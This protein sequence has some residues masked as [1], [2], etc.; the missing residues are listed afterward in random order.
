MSTSIHSSQHL[1]C[2]FSIIA[3]LTAW[4][5]S[6]WVFRHIFF[7]MGDI[8]HF[9]HILFEQCISSSE[10]CALLFVVNIFK[11]WD[12]QGFYLLVFCYQTE[13]VPC[14]V[15]WKETI[16]RVKMQP[17]VL[18]KIFANHILTLFM[19]SNDPLKYTGFQ[20]RSHNHYMIRYPL[21]Q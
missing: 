19:T 13:R 7:M 16:N 20:K 1:F 14:T 18:G 17:M 4:T 21:K 5:V 8:E 9:S 2:I 12:N 11:T 3:I 15:H 10:K 6:P